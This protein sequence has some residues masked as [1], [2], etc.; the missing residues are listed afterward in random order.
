MCGNGSV[1]ATAEC[2]S[3]EDACITEA[4]PCADKDIKESGR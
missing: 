3:I 1:K 4:C 2:S